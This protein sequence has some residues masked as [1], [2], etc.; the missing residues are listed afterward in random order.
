M[1]AI[2]PDD[3]AGI[4]STIDPYA[5]CFSEAVTLTGEIAKRVK[6]IDG[7]EWDFKLQ[8]EIGLEKDRIKAWRD[9][10]VAWGTNQPKKVVYK[11]FW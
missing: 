2:I 7:R 8:K 4:L 6:E 11:S 9:V 5:A 3:A 1:A 10:G